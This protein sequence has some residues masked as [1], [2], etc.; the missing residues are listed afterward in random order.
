MLE[1]SNTQEYGLRNRSV[2]KRDLKSE[3]VNKKDEMTS[4]IEQTSNKTTI[5]LAAGFTALLIA[6]V[7]YKIIL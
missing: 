5:I 4:E 3:K 2:A 6:A 1:I 7:A